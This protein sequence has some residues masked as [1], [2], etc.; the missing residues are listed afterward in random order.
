MNDELLSG[1]HI[2]PSNLGMKRGDIKLNL[3]MLPPA[4]MIAAAKSQKTS[5]NMLPFFDI[6]GST[7]ASDVISGACDVLNEIAAISYDLE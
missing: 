3:T 1:E 2:K 4:Q 6:E 5:S 7:E